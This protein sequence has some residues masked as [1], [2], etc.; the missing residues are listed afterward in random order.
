MAAAAPGQRGATLAMH[1]TLGFMGGM[2]GPLAI[3]MVLDGAGGGGV[4]LAWGLGC[5]AMG[6]G[7]ALTLAAILLVA[8]RQKD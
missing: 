4:V 1:A 7:S 8:P 6:V 5:A 3:G 2:F